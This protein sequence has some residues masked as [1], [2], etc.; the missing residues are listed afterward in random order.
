MVSYRALRQFTIVGERIQQGSEVT[1]GELLESRVSPALLTARGFV[2]QVETEE[3]IHKDLFVVNEA[4]NIDGKAYEQG[5]LIRKSMI[6]KEALKRLL[7]FGVIGEI[8]E[9]E[10][11]NSLQCPGQGCFAM[12]LTRELRRRHQKASGH[13]RPYKKAQP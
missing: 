7:D 4:R 2:T 9:S 10:A 8:T 11:I 13:K 6:P 3:A 5:Q 12:F 1:R